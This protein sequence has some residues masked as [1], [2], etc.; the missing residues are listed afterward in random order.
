MPS[1][2]RHDKSGR[3]GLAEGP[4][5]LIVSVATLPC[6]T[7]MRPGDW[8]QVTIMSLGYGSSPASEEQPVFHAQAEH[9]HLTLSPVTDSVEGL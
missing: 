8:Q 2:A 4:K 3:H 1:S 6:R 5:I 9:I 7:M